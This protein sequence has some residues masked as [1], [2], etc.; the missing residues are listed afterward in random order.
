MEIKHQILGKINL[1]KYIP[2][3]VTVKLQSFKDKEKNLQ[4]KKW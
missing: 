2:R 4:K 1:K 3:H